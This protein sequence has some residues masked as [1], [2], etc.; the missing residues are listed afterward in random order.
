MSARVGPQGVLSTKGE[1]T[2]VTFVPFLL[3]MNH[4]MTNERLLACE[5]PLTGLTGVRLRRRTVLTLDMAPK[6]IWLAKR[7]VTEV[8]FIRFFA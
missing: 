8:T 7:S 3:G 1:P 4:S 5:S 2:L 6:M